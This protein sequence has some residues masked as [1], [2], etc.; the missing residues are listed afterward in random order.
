DMYCLIRIFTVNIKSPPALFCLCINEAA[1]AL[2]IIYRFDI[3][4][5][6]KG[7][8][9]RKRFLFQVKPKY[10]VMC[11]YEHGI[12]VNGSKIV[13]AITWKF[14]A[15]FQ[16]Q[17]GVIGMGIQQAISPELIKA[18]CEKQLPFGVPYHTMSR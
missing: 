11:G 5:V 14:P 16:L 1:C 13:T 7:L 12:N 6:C 4:P 8:K 17:T 18:Q 2:I 9:D 15:F 10:I 3:V